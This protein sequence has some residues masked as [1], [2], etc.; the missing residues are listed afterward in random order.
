M[1]ELAVLLER[2]QSLDDALEEHRS[3]QAAPR[4]L[5]SAPLM[6]MPSQSNGLIS[7][8][9]IPQVRTSSARTDSTHNSA[10][11]SNAR[12]E[13]Q[14]SSARTPAPPPPWAAPS[15]H[16]PGLGESPSLGRV[17]DLERRVLETQRELLERRRRSPAE[18]SSAANSEAVLELQR[19]RRR[20]AEKDWELGVLKLQLAGKEAELEAIRRVHCWQDLQAQ[21][22]ADHTQ[23]ELERLRHTA[24]QQQ[25]ENEMLRVQLREANEEISWLWQELNSRA[26]EGVQAP[27]RFAEGQGRASSF[28]PRPS[29]RGPGRGPE[30]SGA[31]TAVGRVVVAT[32]APGDAAVLTQASAA[33]AA[34]SSP[35]MQGA[36]VQAAEALRAAM[37][38]EELSP[39]RL[40]AAPTPAKVHALPDEAEATRASAG[41]QAMKSP[42]QPTSPP[43]PI[44]PEAP[45]AL[46]VPPPE[47]AAV[48]ELNSSERLRWTAVEP[49]PA[50]ETPKPPAAAD[51]VPPEVTSRP[52]PPSPGE[53]PPEPS[54]SATPSPAAVFSINFFDDDE[55]AAAKEAK[56]QRMARQM[57]RR[58][59]ARVGSRGSCNSAPDTARRPER[60]EEQPETRHEPTAVDSARRWQAA[61]RPVEAVRPGEI[62]GPP[63]APWSGAAPETTRPAATPETTRPSPAPTPSMPTK[64]T[65]RGSPPAVQ[66]KQRAAEPPD[67]PGRATPATSP[68]AATPSGTGAGAAAEKPEAAACTMGGASLARTAVEGRRARLAGLRDEMKRRRSEKTDMD[69]ECPL[70]HVQV[71]NE[72]L[73][74]ISRRRSH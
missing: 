51:P 33:S 40:T 45:E 26:K 46:E 13:P 39:T 10:C 66:R 22:V 21:N 16:T 24:H 42:P 65:P 37:P 53:Q 47:A 23:A 62:M 67:T 72:A 52:E 12:S 70:S 28:A 34:G 41:P 1:E 64:A 4:Y 18:R 74:E 25:Q 59:L 27:S 55:D 8:A 58:R 50:E 69:K 57:E 9:R 15:P 61:E 44:A 17:G 63:E 31:S 3:G 68:A 35:A 19:L 43:G 11:E 30:L 32:Q 54:G 60:R 71:L 2:R 7:P 14:I 20:E 38:H 36:A 48:E 56:R 5:Q 6:S 73:A 49:G 29:P